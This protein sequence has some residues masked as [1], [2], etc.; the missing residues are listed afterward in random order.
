MPYTIHQWP[1]S[2]QKDEIG[3]LPPDASTAVLVML[4]GMRTKG[5]FPE[6]YNIKALSNNLH[7]IRQ[8]NLKINK[9]QIRV[10]FSVYGNRIVVLHVFKKTSPQIEQRGYRKALN[11]KSAIEISLK[12][13]GDVPAVH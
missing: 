5:P 10:L 3:A 9:E 13:G 6:E 11:R 4:R 12:G 2:V 1:G 7:G 8:A